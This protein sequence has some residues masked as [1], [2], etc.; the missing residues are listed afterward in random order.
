MTISS[1]KNILKKIKQRKYLNKDF[2]GFRKDLLEYAKT[3]FPENINDFSESSLGGM[4][5][6]LASYVGDVESF[7]LDHQFHEMNPET[8]IETQNIET[9]LRNAGVP[10][11]G[12]SPAVVNQTFLIEVN[13]I[14]IDNEKFVP[15]PAMLPI[16]HEGTIVPADNG[17]QFELTED[18]DFTKTD[19]DGNYIASKTPGSY[20]NN[21][22]IT[23][24]IMSLTGEC[25]SGFITTENFYIGNFE[26]FKKFILSKE[27]VTEIISVNDNQG[28]E[29]FEVEYLTQDTVFQRSDNLEDDNTLVRDTL[30]IKPAPFRFISRMTL[31]TRLTTLTFGGGSAESLDDDIIPDPSEFAIPLYGKKNFSRFTINP[32]NLLQ[33]TTLGTIAPNSTITVQYRYGGGLSH[34]VGPERIRGVSSVNISFPNNPQPNEAQFVRSSLDSINY[35]NAS[36]G[37]DPPTIDELKDKIPS[38]KASQSRIVS[39]EDLLA[40]IY[41]MPSNFGRVFR[42]T[43]HKSSTNPLATELYIISRDSDGLLILSPDKLKENISTYINEYRLTNDAIDVLDARIIN[44]Q[45]DI[46]ISAETSVNKQLLKQLIIEKVKE[47]F[48]IKN[49]EIDQPIVLNDLDNI[50]Y[51]NIGVLSV[52][53]VV[54][55]NIYGSI[56]TTSNSV[57]RVY[58]AD[59]YDLKIGTKHKVMYPPK[60]GI[61]ELKY[62]DFD[63]RCV[64]V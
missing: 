45:I 18:L 38:I 44:I 35:R 28:N 64:V 29:Y 5:L 46:S 12:A 13:A 8:A 41:T 52:N 54:V 36:G 62:P 30:T 39:K 53:Q 26:P 47:Y 4:F 17:V 19:V 6:E 22:N 48:A 25:I 34:N 58:S 24:F 59:A 40:R 57:P 23:T 63:V 9:H 21:G 10:I 15:N 32:A 55:K 1:K 56:K 43:A 27:N 61:F 33:T 3:H 49:F 2:E 7:Y 20:D 37:E 50:I 11:V 31:D 42:A 60:G 51:N 14:Q 16:I